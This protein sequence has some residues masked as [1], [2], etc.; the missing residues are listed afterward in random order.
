[1]DILKILLEEMEKLVEKK[2]D[3][4]N[5]PVETMGG[6]L[7]WTELANCGKWRLQQNMVTKHCRILDE[8]DRRVAWGSYEGMI[9]ALNRLVHSQTRI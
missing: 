7:V 5:L 6:I 1:M 2:L 3:M 4:P 8:E 9:V